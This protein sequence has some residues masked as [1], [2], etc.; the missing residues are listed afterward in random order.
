MLISLLALLLISNALTLRKDKSILFSRVVMI[1]LVHTSFL[2][3]N[4]LF[5]LALDK[6]LGIFGGLFHVTVFTQIFNIFIFILTGL[7]LTLTS[8][9]PRKVF[10]NQISSLSFLLLGKFNYN[11]TKISNKMS[12][13]FRIL[14]Y[15]LIIV[16]VLSGGVFLMSASDLISI[17]LA[18]ELQS[19]GLYI[20]STLY[21]DSEQSTSGGLT[22]FLIGGLAS[23]FILLGSSLLYANSGTTSLEGIYVISSISEVYGNLG[24]S[25]NGEVLSWYKPYYIHISL[26][27]LAVGFLVKISAAPF[28]FWSPEQWSGKSLALASCTRDKLPNSG[29][30]LELK[31]PSHSRKAAGGWIN[32]SYKVTSLK[33]SEKKVGNRGSK[34]VTSLYLSKP[35]TVKEQRVYGSW[36]GFSCLRC[37][38]LGFERNRWIKIPSNQ[39]KQTRLYTNSNNII[40]SKKGYNLVLPPINNT[41]SPAEQDLATRRWRQDLN[42]LF[43]TGF[44]D[45]EGC[46]TLILRKSPRSSTGWKIEANF[47]IN[48]HKKDR[49]LLKCIQEFFCGIGR[50]S[51]ESKGF[52]D[53]TVSS[54]NQIITVIFPHFDNYPLI[55]QKQ[56][57]YVLFKKAVLMMNRG[58]H[59]TSKGLNGIINIKA[60]INRGLTPALKEA[61]PNYIPEKR[62]F[63]DVKSLLH[64][65][66]YWVA[67]FASG[68]GSFIARVRV[69]YSNLGKRVELVFVLTQHYRDISLI[70]C[71]KDFFGCGQVYTYK[72]YA[73]FKCQNLKEIYVKILP[74]FLEYPILG[75]KSSDFQ[76]WTKIAEIINSS[77]HLTQEGFEKIRHIKQGMNKNRDSD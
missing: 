7:I 71:L 34:S 50:V 37:T 65:H 77:A 59:L 74:F 12:G 73:E 53:F 44:A 66:P 6:G 25:F 47:I 58:E 4:N 15:S 33:T 13:Q 8:F 19:Y 17:F 49:K 2:A 10:L 64:I 42:P 51:K 38:L 43:V 67:G 61:F 28:H 30:T 27:I 70:E 14:E 56:A 29:D 46:F 24:I 60:S 16:F 40:P 63:I 75:V 45:A 57:D 39:I 69:N 31:V 68:D 1:S 52:C 48:L 36:H 54:L 3:Y 11:K 26:I 35:H 21:R 32:L 55:S 62:P 20:M 22:Y 5:F 72:K 23:C 9:Y 18:I 41:F 76:D